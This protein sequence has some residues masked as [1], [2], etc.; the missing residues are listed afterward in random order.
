MRRRFPP[1]KQLT[2]DTSL[3]GHGIVLEFI[4]DLDTE[5]IVLGRYEYTRLDLIDLPLTLLA[6]INGPGNM[7]LTRVALHIVRN[8]LE[9]TID[10]NL[11]SV[12]SIWCDEIIHDVKSGHGTDHGACSRSAKDGYIRVRVQNL[13]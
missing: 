13:G 10:I 2:Y 4:N 7:P 1:F 11:R 6:L 5:M 3:K 9:A 8:V 12:V